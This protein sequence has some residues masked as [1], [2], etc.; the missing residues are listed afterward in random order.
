MAN[1]N[2]KPKRLACCVGV[3]IHKY[4]PSANLT[5]AMSDA[6]SVATILADSE[7]GEFDTVI[8]LVNEEATKDD[9]LEQLR[10]ML[11]KSRL[12]RNDTV[13]FY[14]SG[15]G[16]LDESENICLVTHDTE[17]NNGKIDPTSAIHATDLQLL[18]DNT[19]TGTVIV[20]LDACHS[21]TSG[22]LLG[23]LEYRD[24]SNRMLIGAARFSEYAW[25]SPELEHGRFTAYLLD[26]ANLRPSIGQWITL[27]QALAHIQEE[28]KWSENTPEQTIEVSSHVIDHQIKL[29]K[30]PQYALNSDDFV[31]HVKTLC[32]LSNCDIINAQPDRTFPN[33]FIIREMRSFGRSDDSLFICLNNTVV[34]VTTGELEQSKALFQKLKAT[35]EIVDGLIISSK[36]VPK[37]LSRSLLP[38]ISFQTIHE[39]EQRLINF[40]R[41]LD[42][43]IREFESGDPERLGHPPLNDIYVEVNAKPYGTKMAKELPISSTISEWIEDE[44]QS[45]ALILSGYG[46]G[47][48]TFS[49]KLAYQLAS[50]YKNSKNKS[51]LRIPILIPMRRFP[52]FSEW[53]VEAF[54]IAHLKKSCNVA[55][56]DYEAFQVMNNAGMFVLIFDGFDEMSVGA[57]GTQIKRN[58]LEIAKFASHPK[59]KVLITSRPEAFLSEIEEKDVLSHIYDNRNIQMF[60][61]LELCLFSSEQLNIFLQ[62]RIPFINGNGNKAEDW[63][64][65]R[66]QIDN[67]IGLS[68]LVSR[69][70]LLEITINALPKLIAE[71]QEITRPRLYETYLESE[72]ERQIIHK[73][74]NFLI[75]NKDFRLRLAEEIA[76]HLFSDEN[77]G[78][79]LT[80]LEMQDVLGAE[81]TKEQ[82][83][84]LDAYVRD[85]ISCSFMN[86]SENDFRFSHLSFAEYLA[87][88]A[89][90]REIG[91]VNPKFMG[92]GYFTPQ[93]RNFIQEILVHQNDESLQWRKVLWDWIKDTA[94]QPDSDQ[95]YLGGNSISLFAHMGE[96]LMGVELQN[97]VLLRAELQDVDL[98]GANLSGA[99]LTKSNLTD[100][101][102]NR[103]DLSSSILLQTD[104]RRSDLTDA[105]LQLADLRA[106]DLRDANLSGACF[107]KSNLA[108]CNLT[109]G[110][111][112][113][114]TNFGRAD[115][116]N[117]KIWSLRL[118]NDTLSSTQLENVISKSRIFNKARVI[119]VQY[120]EPPK[121]R[122]GGGGSGPKVGIAH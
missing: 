62:K 117:A 101:Q 99:N 43:L 34:D 3:N 55:N 1:N 83:S 115:L 24:S 118:E 30:N 87:A 86:R 19:D 13:L 21:G 82:R 109:N 88:R 98:S 64:Y 41:Y 122:R 102:L 54:I 6:R 72:I 116:S 57:D 114:K 8:E 35:N 46:T 17:I 113:S 111:M 95:E 37:K 81:F 61:R 78:L 27:Q 2:E 33:A 63:K 52:K 59:A 56:P 36:E 42:K 66:Q 107:L 103:S 106:V 31:Q 69:P 71:G 121:I 53:D 4:I 15:H 85:F 89:V 112:S 23:R 44:D 120:S 39:I 93:I 5:Y 65:Y 9:V 48:T 22:K 49:R 26:A 97:T 90:V 94:N 11:L 45:A 12:N 77:R 32:E 92:R 70:V 60:R 7:F 110:R 67:T 108:D 100:S 28:L 14:F 50:A 40:D 68:D 38:Q 51:G 80:A 79:S 18:M 73:Q 76:C 84:N 29:F 74:R 91:S 104:L 58:F 47:K 96:P 20:I 25:E 16:I 75:H 10:K 105:K 119:G